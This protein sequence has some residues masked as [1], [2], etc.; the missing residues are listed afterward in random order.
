MLS[1][2]GGYEAM[3]LS[4]HFYAGLATAIGATLALMLKLIADARPENRVAH[5]WYPVV[6]SATAVALALAGHWGAA[7]THGEDYLT[8]FAP[9]PVRR[10]LGLP[11][12]RDPA[13]QPLKPL[14]DR[15]L[16]A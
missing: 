8:E 4:R 9:N 7:I 16:F 1:F 3:I 11:V 15:V 5:L 13:D 10:A 2:S 12:R 14:A 6:L